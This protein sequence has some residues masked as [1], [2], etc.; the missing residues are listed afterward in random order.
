MTSRFGTCGWSYPD[1]VGC[2]YADGSVARDWLPQYA[3]SLD[4]VEADTTFYRVPPPAL[5][6]RWFECT[7]A[8]FR[9]TLK[10]PQEVTHERKLVGIA[11]PLAHFLDVTSALAEKRAAVLFQFP[12]FNRKVF[13][14]AG[15][16]YDRLDA[17]L[18]LVPGGVRC[19][20]EIRNRTYLTVEYL[21]LLASHAAAPAL[22]SQP[23]MPDARDYLSMA[24]PLWSDF[25]YVR[26]LGDRHGIEEMTTRWDRTIID[27]SSDIASWTELVGRISASTPDVDV[28]VLANNHYAGHAPDTLRQ[29]QG[30]PPERLAVIA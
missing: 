7:P 3:S 23:W 6:K 27:R 29:L 13:A 22:T 14:S 18:K 21:K 24:G 30:M 4:L 5:V 25:A 16:F 11:S 2:F 12:Y 26:L 8:D 20:V 17:T 19:A 10:V 9:F 1:W 15:E 28:Y